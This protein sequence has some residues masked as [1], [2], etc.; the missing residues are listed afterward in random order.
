MTTQ[1]RQTPIDSTHAPAPGWFAPLFLAM[2]AFVVYY[3]SLRGEFVF[4]DEPILAR[5][6]SS[7]VFWPLHEA[8]LFG[9]RAFV[10]LSWNLNHA[11]LGA[12]P[13][14]Y[15]AVN[16]A[17]HIL[18]TIALYLLAQLLLRSDKMPDHL[19]NHSR[20]L[21][22]VI[23]LIWTVHPLN[24]ESVTY[25]VQRYESM[26]GMLILFVLYFSARAALAQDA[27]RIGAPTKSWCWFAL[28]IVTG[29]LALYSKEIAAGIAVP[30]LLM[31]RAF[32]SGSF[33]N[34]LKKRGWFYGA[35][36]LLPLLYFVS[37]NATVGL[38]ASNDS[39]VQTFNAGFG[40]TQFS[41]IQYLFSQ[42]GAI[43]HYFR[44]AFWPHPLCFDYFDWMPGPRLLDDFPRASVIG[45]LVLA[46]FWAIWKR[47]A[48][49][50]IG[51]FFFVL[52]APSSSFIPVRDVV[53]EHRMYLPLIAI[54]TLVVAGVWTLMCRA[55]A[56]RNMM[57]GA[58]AAGIFA[59]TIIVIALASLTVLRNENYANSLELLGQAAEVRPNNPRPLRN[60][61]AILVERHD[62]PQW[63][64]EAMTC[65]ARAIELEPNDV[66][67]RIF[68]ARLAS[69]IGRHE[70]AIEQYDKILAGRPNEAPVY[71]RRGNARL[72]QGKIDA[73]LDDF[74][75]AILENP[76]FAEPHA[77][78][79]LALILLDRRAEGIASMRRAVELSPNEPT[80]RLS[81]AG[82]LADEPLSQARA[83]A[84]E[85][86][87]RL[88]QSHPR[89]ASAWAGAGSLLVDEGKFDEG[90]SRLETA[91]Q[92][93]PGNP[94]Y[95]RRVAWAI[96]VDARATP[97]QASRALQLAESANRATQGSFPLVLDALA[98]A[99][100][101]LGQFD[102]AIVH[103][104][105][106]IAQ[107]AHFKQAALEKQIESRLARYQAR[108]AYTI[109][110]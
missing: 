73:A 70:L 65:L 40:A 22:F 97:T 90:L 53:V 46:T 69:E 38:V 57:R 95:Q 77:S 109:N 84:R 107:A 88:T 110:P 1:H 72:Q 15:H 74:S 5:V 98:A 25:I 55:G 13:A 79:G 58:V 30:A 51:A 80:F 85:M 89:V 103:A 50:F 3:N 36:L 78:R 18:A 48:I 52:L 32:V 108:Q 94:D 87:D 21:A 2:A 9:R 39:S 68:F 105:N 45:V 61:A 102:E 12:Q 20:A 99:H 67:G 44:L 59:V 28:A 92:L 54:I 27:P 33:K 17:I 49:G 19:R 7:P 60:M 75:R 86:F 8:W 11:L 26:A 104:R 81:L 106:A 62:R 83:E 29:I 63:R 66:E 43:L 71:W 35:L 16:I 37:P 10:E 96:A 101:R 47:P 100:A 41:P 24:T 93:E 6:P 82:A 64:T 31:D 34:S 76:N 14:G 4:D 42:G 56:K 23:A 91:L